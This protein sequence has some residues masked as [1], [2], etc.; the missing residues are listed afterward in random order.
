MTASTPMTW[1]SAKGAISPT[2]PS[3]ATTPT[4]SCSRSTCIQVHRH[5]HVQVLSFATSSLFS[6]T[7]PPTLTLGTDYF[8]Y[9]RTNPTTSRSSPRRCTA[10]RRAC[11]CISSRRTASTTARQMLVV[12]GDRPAEQLAQL[13]RHGGQRRSL[14]LSS[15]GEPARRIHRHQRHA[16]AQRPVARRAPGDRPERRPADRQ[17]RPR[18]VVRIQREQHAHSGPGRHDLSGPGNQHLLPGH[19]NRPGRCD[20]AD[21][22]RVVAHRVC[23]GL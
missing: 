12:V 5:F 23:L 9:D 22:Q 18:P 1:M 16:V 17:R 10:P 3:S 14:Y 4:K 19:R 8:S 2:S 6:S 21:L 13:H 20:R 15:L 11:P 7:P